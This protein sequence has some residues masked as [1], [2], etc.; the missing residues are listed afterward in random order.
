[1]PD[2]DLSDV[3][4]IV[5]DVFGDRIS[6]VTITIEEKSSRGGKHYLAIVKAPGYETD[7]ALL[8][9]NGH[10][11][12]TLLL[13][14]EQCDCPT[15]EEA[16]AAML[17]TKLANSWVAGQPVA[18]RA[19]ATPV[20]LHPDRAWYRCEPGLKDAVAYS[21]AFSDQPGGLHEPPDDRD[22][23]QR[24]SFKTL[25]PA[26]SLQLVFWQAKNGWHY[27]E[28][29]IDV[30]NT[31]AKHLLDVLLIHPL[32]GQPDPRVVAQLL[33]LHCGLPMEFAMTPLDSG[34]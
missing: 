1:M 13:D 25:E 29:D 28:A 23:D 10:A 21:K 32:T 15:M 7:S 14:P 24:G 16:Q 22:W 11:E 26:C 12:L 18:S 6:D 27:F 8:D 17:A 33:V 3:E 30:N 34:G 5:R 9:F 31:L 2:F 20:V 19:N 4:V